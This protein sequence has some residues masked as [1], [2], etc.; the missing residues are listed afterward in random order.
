LVLESELKFKEFTECR[1]KFAL[2][3]KRYYDQQQ[4][5]R[6]EVHLKVAAD[7]LEEI[8]RL[9]SIIDRFNERFIDDETHIA[10]FKRSLTAFIEK[11]VTADLED[12]CT[13]G[14]MSRIWSLEN[15]MFRKL[16]HKVEHLINAHF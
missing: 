6:A 9:E 15:E 2:F 4:T 5:I 1:E 3:E 14:L 16:F 8:G 10:A 11:E 7:F 12:K 13:G